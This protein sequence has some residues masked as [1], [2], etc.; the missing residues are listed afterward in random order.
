MSTS[1]E[2]KPGIG[3]T[4][5]DSPKHDFCPIISATLNYRT[6]FVKG[7]RSLMEIDMN[8]LEENLRLWLRED[9]GHGD[10]ST[11][12]TVPP[13]IVGKGRFLMKED[14]V[15]CGLTVVAK[16]F[17]IV[18]ERIVV[19]P[20]IEEGQAVKKGDVIAEV[21]GDLGKIMGGERV[22]LNLLQRL[23]GI[24]T[25]TRAFVNEIQGFKAKILDTRK[26]TPGLRF[27]EKYA[28]TIGGGQNHRFGLYDGILIKDNHIKAAGGITKALELLNKT[29]PHY[30]AVQVEVE[31]LDE[32][33]EALEFKVP[34]ILLDNMTTEMM[35]EAVAITSG[36]AKLEASGNMTVERVREVAATGVDYI[37]AGSLTHSVKALD[38]S[39]KVS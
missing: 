12:L 21:S 2:T 29:A 6:Q 30:L 14:G 31:T 32:L 16:T 23:S 27:L 28:V 22:A 20:L 25:R 5:S 3:Q 4:P 34:A 38:I 37:S 24:S 17:G 8:I 11:I 19:T 33:R 35:A 15:I 1:Q 9:I 7:S 26:T 18:D 39:L 13:G 10:V 36:R